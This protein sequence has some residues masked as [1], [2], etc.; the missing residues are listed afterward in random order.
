MDKSRPCS[1]L[2]DN[3]TRMFDSVSVLLS[4]GVLVRV[5][6]SLNSAWQSLMHCHAARGRLG[7]LEVH[8][9]L[10]II[11]L[12]DDYPTYL[13]MGADSVGSERM[14]QTRMPLLGRLWAR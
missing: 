9:F 12:L 3:W 7:D 10:R 13:I 11:Q 6:S 4:L 8:N 2:Q 5:A 14:Q 1:V